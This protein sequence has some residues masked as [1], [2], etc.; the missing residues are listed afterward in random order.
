MA[1]QTAATGSPVVPR[2]DE[3]TLLR[4]V[5][6]FLDTDVRGAV[7]DRGL[8]FRLRIAA[9]LLATTA[10]Q[11]E[12]SEVLEHGALDSLARLLDAE[13]ASEQPRRDA[14]NAL[15]AELGARLAAGTV[16]REASLVWL[17]DALRTQLTLTSPRFDLATDVE[18]PG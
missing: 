4:A 1:A 11:L 7:T 3:P 17:Q 18:H 13:P 10:A 6:R 2:P 9:H 8:A 16:D 5:A 14:L 12:Q 15:Q